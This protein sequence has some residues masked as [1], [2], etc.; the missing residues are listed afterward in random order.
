MEDGFELSEKILQL[1]YWRKHPNLHGYIVQTFAKGVDNCEPIDLSVD[2]LQ[3]IIDAVARNALPYTE[4]LFVGVSDGTERD[5]DIRIFT[6]ALDWL[7][8]I[9]DGVSAAST[10][11]QAGNHHGKRKEK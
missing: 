11:E 8:T 10:T 7:R 6:A 4:G 2:D 3:K 1:G 5:A 9:E